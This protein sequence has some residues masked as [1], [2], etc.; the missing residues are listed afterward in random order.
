MRE[1]IIDNFAGGGGASTGIELAT[2]RHVDIAINH[3][4]KAILMHKTNHPKTKH[5]CESV[6]DVD[7]IE[8]TQGQA[9]HYVGLVQTASILV[10]R[11]EK[12]LLI[13]K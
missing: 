11:K 12:H 1:L 4:P 5:Y 10:E 7:P 8:A 3:D 2:G 6:W 13:K 9:V